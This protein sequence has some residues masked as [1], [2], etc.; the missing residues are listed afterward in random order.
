M[1]S[2]KK[3]MIPY[4]KNNA[5]VFQLFLLLYFNNCAKSTKEKL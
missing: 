3:K 1:R 5:F 4:S 2:N